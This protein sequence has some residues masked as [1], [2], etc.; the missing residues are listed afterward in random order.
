V[1]RV[2]ATTG[3]PII[4]FGSDKISV[5][6]SHLRSRTF[7][8]ETI[9]R[10]SEPEQH[11]HQTQISNVQSGAVSRNALGVAGQLCGRSL[12]SGRA[13]A[14]DRRTHVAPLAREGPQDGQGIQSPCAAERQGR[15]R[16]GGVKENR[17]WGRGWRSVGSVSE[18]GGARPGH[19]GG[20][21]GTR[22]EDEGMGGV[23]VAE[24]AEGGR[25]G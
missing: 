14:A 13:S 15:R 17:R 6:I 19:A 18:A 10:R 24:R 25:R 20:H 9:A 7:L 5:S 12:S 2:P 4:T 3:F 22:P 16:G 23:W 21:E 8:S 11:P 1:M